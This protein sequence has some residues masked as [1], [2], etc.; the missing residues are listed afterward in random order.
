MFEP[1]HGSAPKYGGQ[2]AASPI[3]TIGAVGL[4]LEHVGQTAAGAAI[5]EAI[6]AAF[7]TGRV[8]GVEARAGR[9]FEDAKI[10]AD[11]VAG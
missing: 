11:L 2:K 4:L 9:T 1:I 7:R 5:T 3:G 6:F 8:D 10:I